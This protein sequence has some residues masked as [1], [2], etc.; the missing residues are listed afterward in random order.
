MTSELEPPTD[1]QFVETC[2]LRILG[3]D[4]DPAGRQRCLD[5]LARGV[6][7]RELIAW[8]ASRD[9]FLDRQQ[10]LLSLPDPDTWGAGH[11]HSPLPDLDQVATAYERIVPLDRPTCPGIDLRV[12]EQ[13]RLLTEF[14]PL[15][16]ALPF[17]DE[18]DGRHRYHGNNGLFQGADAIALYSMLRTRRPRRVIEVG[19]GFSS[20]VM[21]DTNE[22]FLDHRIRFTFIDPAPLRLH[23]LLRGEDKHAVEI[24]EG[25]VMDVPLGLFEQLEANDI[26]FIDSSHVGKFGSDVT[27]IL[28]EVLPR[29]K[30]GVV[31]HFHDIFW[32]FDYPPHWFLMGRAWNEA[33]LLRAFLTH[34]DAFSILF[35]VDWLRRFERE[36]LARTLPLLPHY[37]GGSLWLER[38][39]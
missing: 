35:F 3:R 7:R 36:L 23:E 1:E 17:A 31:V 16:E 34:N 29:L 24:V 8:F 39:R 5:E 2:F 33:Y 19:S 10:R 11:F 4:A 12:D 20:A 6:S 26:L 18:P 13:R 37:P 15:Q 28:G 32:P 30:P 9:E 27:W 21:L 14:A 38:N 25:L 22:L